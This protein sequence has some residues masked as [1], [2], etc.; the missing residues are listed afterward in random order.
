MQ[1][2]VLE[3]EAAPS[4][5]GPLRRIGFEEGIGVWLGA[6][7]QAE[8][9]AA[10]RDVPH[11][12]RLLVVLSARAAEAGPAIGLLCRGGAEVLVAGERL[13]GLDEPGWAF[14]ASLSRAVVGSMLRLRSGDSLCVLVPDEQAFGAARSAICRGFRWRGSWDEAEAGEFHTAP[15]PA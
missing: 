12:G 10:C 1:S 6:A 8:A 14:E 5:F 2:Q 11:T 15:R 3:Q 9:V 7:S 13:P 4:S